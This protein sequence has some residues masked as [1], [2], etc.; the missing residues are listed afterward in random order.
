MIQSRSNQNNLLRILAICGIAAPFLFTAL[1]TAGGLIYEGYSHTTQ[2]ISELGGVEAQYPLL[3]NTNFFVVGVLI[4][5]FALGLHRG[6]GDGQGSRLGP[7][8]LG[9]F[10]AIMVSH[11]FLSCDPGCEFESLTGA[12][13]NLTGLAGFI[14]G[15]AGIFVI[16][17]RLNGDPHWHSLYRFSRVTGVA[18]LV[19]LLLWIGVAKAAEV[20]S[21]NGVLQRVFIATWFIWVAVMATQLFRVSGWAKTGL[22][23]T[24]SADNG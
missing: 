8:L 19:S 11:G 23:P 4:M 2:A 15:I 17:R 21:L 5:A 1:V 13:H 9:I 22:N 12:M 24:V 18:A 20:E 10:G 14:A 3:Q 16:S 7:V 6:T